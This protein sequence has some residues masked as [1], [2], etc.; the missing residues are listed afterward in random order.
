MRN[1]QDITERLTLEQ[2]LRE[3]GDYLEGELAGRP[4]SIVNAP[5]NKDPGE[6]S[7]C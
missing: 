5:T 1:N 2:Q 7:T 3:A 6:D 4:V